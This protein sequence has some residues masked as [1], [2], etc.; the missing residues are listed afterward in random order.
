MARQPPLLLHG[1]SAGDTLWL[2]TTRGILLGLAVLAA[3]V[4][5]GSS[6]VALVAAL[7]VALALIELVSLALK[8]V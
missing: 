4:W 2:V 7:F 5:N 3:A 6:V 1:E 8:Y